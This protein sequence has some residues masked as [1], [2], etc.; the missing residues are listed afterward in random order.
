M[1]GVLLL[2]ALCQSIR[3]K[4]NSARYAPLLVDR[5]LFPKAFPIPSESFGRY[6]LGIVIKTG[7]KIDANRTITDH[8]KCWGM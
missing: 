6:L 2:E 3:G 8:G 4:S 5:S 1:P 7:P